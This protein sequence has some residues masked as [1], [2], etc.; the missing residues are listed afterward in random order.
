M[1][2]CRLFRRSPLS[3][4]QTIHACGRYYPQE[5]QLKVCREIVAK[6]GYDFQRGRLDLTHHPFETT[7]SVGDV[8]ITTRVKEDLLSECL[9]SVIHESGHAMYEQGVRLGAG[10]D[11]VR[12]RDFIRCS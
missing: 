2:W 11:A 3:R 10:W 7:F 6:L 8:R 12:R 4:R 1:S 9:Y 5:E